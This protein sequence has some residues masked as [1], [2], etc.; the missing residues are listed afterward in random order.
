MMHLRLLD[1]GR[2]LALVDDLPD[3][4]NDRPLGLGAS[5]SGQVTFYT[6]KPTN[7]TLLDHPGFVPPNDKVHGKQFSG[8]RNRYVMLVDAIHNPSIISG[9]V[10]VLQSSPNVEVT[11]SVCDQRRRQFVVVGKRR[12]VGVDELVLLQN[13]IAAWTQLSEPCQDRHFW[14]RQVREEEPGIKQV[15]GT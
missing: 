13:E 8:H 14:A 15:C 6:V 12:V 1:V 7:T 5:K 9:D 2:G 4:E 3:G 10:E 11:P